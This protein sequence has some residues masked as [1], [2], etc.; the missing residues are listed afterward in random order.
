M[1]APLAIL[2]VS[3]ASFYSHKMYKN[4][5]GQRSKTSLSEKQLQEPEVPQKSNK[6]EHPW[7]NPPVRHEAKYAELIHVPWIR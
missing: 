1:K 6:P 5:Q 2:G 3:I 4:Q 7:W